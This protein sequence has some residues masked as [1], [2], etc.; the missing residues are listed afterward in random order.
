MNP[1][2]PNAPG[3]Q[4]QQAAAAA[5]NQQQ[6]A[7]DGNNDP[8]A[9]VDQGPRGPDSIKGELMQHFSDKRRT[10]GFHFIRFLG[11]GTYGT[12][13]LVEDRREKR[14]PPRKLVVKRGFGKG[15][16]WGVKREI[17]YLKLV[18]GGEHFVQLLAYRNRLY[19]EPARE[20][21]HL[22]RTRGRYLQALPG[23]TLVTD[24]VENGNFNDFYLKV[25]TWPEHVP[26]RLLWSI[27]LCGKNSKA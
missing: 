13:A 11:Q 21:R 26:N 22:F 24:Y 20:I 8:A 9:I 1:V 2:D 18:R 10:P 17:E 19:D 27:M 15:G 5:L 6:N 14:G 4:N 3:A 12:A 16:Q 25:C 23:P 7:A